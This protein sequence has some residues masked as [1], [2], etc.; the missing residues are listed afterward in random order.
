MTNA[1]DD[2]RT[3]HA[4]ID[5]HLAAL[6][7][8][9]GTEFVPWSQSRN[10]TEKRPTLNW[11]IHLTRHDKRFLVTDYMQGMGHLPKEYQLK[12]LGRLSVDED[13][14]ERRIA[15]SGKLH[16]QGYATKPV[17]S[18]ELRDIMYS[19]LMDAEAYQYTFENW[20]ADLGYDPDSRKAETLYRACLETGRSLAGVFTAQEL[21]TL[22]DL[23]QD[24]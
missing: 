10:A 5:A 14:C 20:A 23:F 15:E 4:E 7:L 12:N 24:Y 1:A 18:P 19:L 2:T 3:T 9:Y 21:D 17:T 11:R 8:N 6:G 22:R 13:A 16:G